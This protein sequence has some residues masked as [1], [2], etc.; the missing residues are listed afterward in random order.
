MLASILFGLAKVTGIVLNIAMIAFFMAIMINLL[1]AD[2]YNPYVRM[3][4]S[5]TE[6]LCRP[7][8][9]L[10]RRYNGPIDLAQVIVI[11][12]I[13]FLMEVIPRYL[14]SLAQHM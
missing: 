13:V 10:T 2:P 1:N 5:V 4:R 9:K 8:R 7:F 11:L 14:L 6:P 3:I 12:I